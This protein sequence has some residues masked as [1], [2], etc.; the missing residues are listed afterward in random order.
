M[1]WYNG[2]SLSACFIIHSMRT[3]L[4]T[5]LLTLIFVPLVSAQDLE[6][7]RKIIDTNV[8]LLPKV[9]EIGR[10]TP[11]AELV[12]AC[13][14]IVEAAVGIY[15]LPDLTAKDKQ[16][17]LQ[18]E[19]AA[20]AVLAYVDAPR[21]YPRLV[22]VSEELGKRGLQNIYKEI[23][24]HVLLIGTDWAT[25]TGNLQIKVDYEV[26]ANKMYL[27]ALQYPG[28]DS[29]NYIDNFLQKTR[30]MTA[31]PRDKRLAVIGPIFKRYYEGINHT[32][33][34]KAL[35]PDI[36]RSQLK[37]QLLYLNGVDINGK[38]IDITAF[39]DKV[40]LLQFWGTWCPN[41]MQEMPDLIALYEKYHDKGFEIIGVNTGVQGDENAAMVKRFLDTNEFKG[42]KIPWTI[43]HD[44]LSKSK[45]K[46]LTLT[47][48]YGI[49]ELPVLILIGRNGKVLELHPL[50]S[51]LDDSVKYAL[52]PQAAAEAEMTDEEKK[53]AEE[54]QKERDKILDE[55]IKSDLAQPR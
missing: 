29:L 16:W 32:Q 7:Y 39:K 12:T 15:D 17:T 53:Q 28:Q 48:I 44:G 22:I 40:V 10:K 37:G 36:F 33:R 5:C 41:C 25:K 42:K 31:I 6:Q 35:E 2:V 3:F 24:K 4:W 26:L 49:T 43:L 46:D 47:N 38:D 21:Y 9:E 52:S 1:T 50:P 27:Y 34:A 54:R 20:L 45:Y 11:T 55:Q 30:S 8:P 13:K 51:R 19:A 18:R 14:A 23:E